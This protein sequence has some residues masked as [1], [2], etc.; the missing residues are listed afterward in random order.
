[1][2]VMMAMAVRAMFM[3]VMI[4]VVVRVVVVMRVSHREPM[5]HCPPAGSMF[6]ARPTRASARRVTADSRADQSAMRV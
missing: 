6:G 2:V 4:V 3:M 5:S 1:M